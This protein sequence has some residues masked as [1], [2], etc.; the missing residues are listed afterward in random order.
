MKTII[1]GIKQNPYFKY[2]IH[3]DKFNMICQIE[4]E[5]NVV[6][7]PIWLYVNINKLSLNE[8]IQNNKRGYYIKY[9]DM[10]L[11]K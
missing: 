3:I 1:I 6:D 2:T 7:I 11:K 9:S 4:N 5:W 10:N 8:F